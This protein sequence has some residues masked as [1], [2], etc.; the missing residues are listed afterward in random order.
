MMNEDYSK[1]TI[2]KQNNYAAAAEIALKYAKDSNLSL[3]DTM[4]INNF[5]AWI[6]KQ[7]QGYV[8]SLEAERDEL[9]A[10]PPTTPSKG[11]GGASSGTPEERK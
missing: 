10:L 8:E 3:E 6:V 4:A 5:I 2:E 1:W 7:T 11:V 9:I